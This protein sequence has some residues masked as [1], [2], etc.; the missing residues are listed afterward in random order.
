MHKYVPLACIMT[1]SGFTLAGQTSFG[2]ENLRTTGMVGIASG[3][4]AQLNLLNPG[5]QAPALGVICSATVSFVDSTG[6]VLKSATLSVPPG[7]SLSLALKSDVDL[8]LAV[9]E[10][11]EIRATIAI[12]PYPTSATG[13][14]AVPACKVTPTLEVIDTATGR[15]LVTMRHTVLIPS[16]LAANSQRK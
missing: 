8:S 12:P 4:T 3:Q 10:R 11:R 2:L 9:G 5:I 1:L 16:I 13:T 7:Q 15:T 14:A 6:G